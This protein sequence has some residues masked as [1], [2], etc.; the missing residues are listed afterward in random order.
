MLPEQ[1]TTVPIPE[2]PGYSLVKQIWAKYRDTSFGPYNEF[3]PVIPCLFNGQPFLHVPFIYVDN[4][5]AMAAGRETGGWPKKWRGRCQ[6]K[7]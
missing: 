3:M 6:S 7:P 1:C 4:D 2:L 5:S